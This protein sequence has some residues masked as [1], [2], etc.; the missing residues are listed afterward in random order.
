[1]PA[2]H[3]NKLPVAN[4]QGLSPFRLAPQT[5]MIQGGLYPIFI[6]AFQFRNLGMR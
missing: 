1:M 2:R 4:R 6:N 5:M 3:L